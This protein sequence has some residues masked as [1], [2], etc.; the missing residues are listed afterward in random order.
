MVT[1]AEH[2]FWISIKLLMGFV[3][4]MLFFQFSG[5]KKQLSQMTAI[6]LIGNFLLG[7]IT[8]GFLYDDDITLK[9]FMLV[10]VIYFILI[11]TVNTIVNETLWGRKILM[12]VPVVVINDGVFD[13]NKL[14]KTKISMTD[15]MSI[16]REKDIRSL[17][18]IK[19]AQI[20]PT[21]VV[22]I[23]KKG[24]GEYALM[25]VDDG[26]INED[27]LKQIEKDDAWLKEE[28]AKSGIGEVK[29]VFYAQWLNGK[30]YLI[31]NN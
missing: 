6:D 1:P 29:E 21:G 23:V 3:G 15:F 2:Y 20:E 12:G 10:L 5:A 26:I 30:M 31:K 17:T 8:G 14:R 13:V 18:E 25:L 7:A 19:R 11:K 24:E 16:L 22:T 28:L 9:Q 4:I 27:A